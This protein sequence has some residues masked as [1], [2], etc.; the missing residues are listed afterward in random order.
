MR[1]PFLQ[2]VERNDPTL[3]NSD[4]PKDVWSSETDRLSAVFRKGGR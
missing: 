4:S 3:T 1:C 2:R